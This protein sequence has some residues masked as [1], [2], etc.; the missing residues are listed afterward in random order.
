MVTGPR[1]TIRPGAIVARIHSTAHHP[2]DFA[3]V[4]AALL[5]TLGYETLENFVYAA[6]TEEAAVEATLLREVPFSGGSLPSRVYRGQTLTCLTAERRFDLAPLINT[7]VAMYDTPSEIDQR[8]RTGAGLIRGLDDDGVAWSAPRTGKQT[9]LLF[10][11]R[12]QA[13]NLTVA[14]SR[15]FDTVGGHG[16]LVDVCA[17]HQVE[18]LVR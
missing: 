9:Y 16:W 12:V 7:N 4:P 17:R 3:C 10:E 13:G 8:I 15:D 2:Q 5:E 6:E 1:V 14:G 11:D 18:V